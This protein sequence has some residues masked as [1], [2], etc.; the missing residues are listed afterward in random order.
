MWPLSPQIYF[1]HF[2]CFLLHSQTSSQT[3]DRL[4]FRL[5]CDRS[6]ANFHLRSGED[7]AR[8]FFRSTIFIR[9][10]LRKHLPS[11]HLIKGKA[12]WEECVGVG[13]GRYYLINN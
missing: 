11:M 1:T 2:L 12:W 9:V 10:V 8:F 5:L 7:A 6:G 13:G 3:K 4:F